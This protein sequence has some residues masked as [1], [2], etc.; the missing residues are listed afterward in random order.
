MK[1]REEL[2]ARV[3]L[4]KEIKITDPDDAT[5][6]PKYTGEGIPLIR[7]N[8]SHQP[9]AVANVVGRVTGS[10][11]APRRLND[12]DDVIADDCRRDGHNRR[13]RS[14]LRGARE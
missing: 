7:E 3:P 13:A 1:A 2:F 4:G 10:P 8:P 14:A 6:W 5:F 11:D 12:P 9:H